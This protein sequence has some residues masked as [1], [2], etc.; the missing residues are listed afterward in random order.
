MWYTRSRLNMLGK[1]AAREAPLSPHETDR[2]V[3]RLIRTGRTA[4]IQDINRIAERVG[5]APFDTSIVTTGPLAGTTYLGHTLQT[6]DRADWLHLV[7]RVML[8]KQW[9][10]GTQLGEYIAD[11]QNA[12]RV[13]TRI[14][15]YERRGGHVAMFLAPTAGVIPASRIGPSMLPETV[16]I[17]SAD[18]GMIITG[19]QVSGLAT[20]AI[21]G[22]AR[23][24][25]R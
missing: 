22:N 18:R 15:I 6:R 9:K 2:L 5:K 12:A 13:A 17:Y 1:D 3:R 7:K 20:V 25:R 16:V 19:Y 10:E 8:E 14:S 4:T 24:L 21:P 23:W 11:I